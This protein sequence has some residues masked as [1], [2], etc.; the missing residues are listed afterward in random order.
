MMA[1]SDFEVIYAIQYGDKI[2]KGDNYP[3]DLNKRAIGQGLRAYPI[4]CS[5]KSTQICCHKHLRMQEYK[6]SVVLKADRGS[7]SQLARIQRKV[8]VLNPK[9]E[10]NNNILFKSDVL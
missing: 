10:C 4:E 9:E 5:V 7:V 6:H 1:L 2:K 8:R 3:P